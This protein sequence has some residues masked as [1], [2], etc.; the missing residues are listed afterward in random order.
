MRGAHGRAFALCAA[1]A[2]CA[3][4]AAVT[5]DRG[6]ALEL[7]RAPQRIVTLAPHLAELAFALGAGG[8]VVGVSSYSDYPQE[9]T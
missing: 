5:D 6:R 2:V 3:Q 1:L 4:A 8:R 7:K 9:A